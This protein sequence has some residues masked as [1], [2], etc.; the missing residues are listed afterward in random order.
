MPI[1]HSHERRGANLGACN[2]V[3]FVPCCRT[4]IPDED[5]ELFTAMA[6]LFEILDL[7]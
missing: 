5:D 4:F 3:P 2:D 7:A 1:Q 6:E